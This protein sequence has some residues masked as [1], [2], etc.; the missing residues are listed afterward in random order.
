MDI[1]KAFGFVMED[2]RWLTKILIGGLLSLVPILNV[3]TLYG[4][5]L[6]TARNVMQKNPKPL[7][8]WDNF[9]DILMKGLYAFVI[10]LVYAIPVIIVVFAFQIVVV[11]ASS[12]AGGSDGGEGLIAILSLLC[13][14]PLTLV[15]GLAA[16][17]FTMAG[18][19]RYIQTESLG[20]A[21]RFG[22]VIAMVRGSV[23]SWLML[24]V[25]Y[26]LAGLVGMLGLIG[27][28]I[29]VVFTT[30]YGFV[31]F[32]HTLGQVAAQQAGGTGSVGGETIRI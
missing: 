22:E 18:F 21:F 27:C 25:V 13:L 3:L 16:W 8:E 29:G 20:A 12:A 28:G 5:G 31:A 30:F 15:L 10:S 26:I 11:I 7:P 23:G 9:G 17:V 6:T 24:L 2:D 1:G 14:M 4:Y 19:V 32:S